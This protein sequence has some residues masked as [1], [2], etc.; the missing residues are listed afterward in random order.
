[1][2]LEYEC[3]YKIGDIILFKDNRNIRWIISTINISAVEPYYGISRIS[4][5]G[6]IINEDPSMPYTPCVDLEEITIF[7]RD[8]RLDYLLK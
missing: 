8:S 2:K 1:M 5:N 3:K 7:D 6:V 4:D